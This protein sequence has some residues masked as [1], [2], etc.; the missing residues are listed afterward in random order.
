[1]KNKSAN[2]ILTIFSVITTAIIITLVAKS[3]NPK[4]AK[5]VKLN[6]PEDWK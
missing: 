5:P 6:L 1:M 3:I 4:E 2:I